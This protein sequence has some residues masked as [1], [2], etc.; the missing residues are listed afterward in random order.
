VT[1]ASNGQ[2]IAGA[3]VTV[4]VPDDV[5]PAEVFARTVDWFVSVALAR[6]GRVNGYLSAVQDEVLSGHVA[7]LPRDVA[8]SAAERAPVRAGEPA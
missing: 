7:V 5:R 6:E 1:R 8:V 4:A 3:L 2:P